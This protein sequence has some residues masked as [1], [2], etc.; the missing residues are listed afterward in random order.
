MKK[1]Q[2]LS[3]RSK[4]IKK[5]LEFIDCSSYKEAL[6]SKQRGKGIYILYK[7]DEVYYI[8]HSKK[9]LRGRIRKHATKDRHKGKWNRFSFYQIGRTKYIK[10]VESLLLRVFRPRGNRVAGRFKK[11][12]KMA[13]KIKKY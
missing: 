9:S 5:H 10:D 8:G 6:D 1:D 7:E 2:R 13:R 11:R 3:D 12:Y 4:L